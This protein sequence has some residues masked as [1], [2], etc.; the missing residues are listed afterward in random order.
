MRITVK[1]KPKSKLDC[2][3][4]IDETHY[5]VRVKAPPLEGKA[6]EAVIGVLAKHLGVPKSSIEL[7]MGATSKQK[8]FD[9]KR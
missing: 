7:V 1:V 8:V 5:Q 2:V 3:E 4:K 6:N 9:I